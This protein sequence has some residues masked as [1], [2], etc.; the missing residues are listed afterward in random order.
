M[1]ANAARAA[2][3]HTAAT[4]TLDALHATASL[5]KFFF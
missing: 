3:M 4:G 5:I 2:A 1:R